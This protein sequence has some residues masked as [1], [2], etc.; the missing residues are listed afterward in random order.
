VHDLQ[1]KKKKIYLLVKK[2]AQQDALSGGLYA[3]HRPNAPHTIN[4]KK[5]A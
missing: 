2:K 3:T 4:G 5:K 1:K